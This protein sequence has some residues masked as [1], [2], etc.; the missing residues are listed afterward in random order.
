MIPSVNKQHEV[1]KAAADAGK[2]LGRRLN[3]GHDRIEV[4][5]R[6]QQKFMEM[7]EGSA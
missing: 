5:Q 2:L 4:A 6:M 1:M 7:L 3:E